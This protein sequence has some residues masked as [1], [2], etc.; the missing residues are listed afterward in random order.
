MNFEFVRLEIP[1]VILIKPKVFED[2][3]GFF[4]E[5]YKASV[6]T[7]TGITVAFVQNYHSKSK[8]K[9]LIGLHYQLEPKEQGKLVRCIKGRIWDVA[10]DI[11][12]GSPIFR[13]W[14]A[15]E[16]SKENKYMLWIPPGFAHGFLASVGGVVHRRTS[17]YFVLVRQ[18]TCSP[19]L[20]LDEG[21]Q[22]QPTYNGLS[23]QAT[24][25]LEGLKAQVKWSC[26]ALLSFPCFNY[27]PYIYKNLGNNITNFS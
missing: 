23:R 19:I 24:N 10:V 7:E 3:W 8:K 16:L 13:K 5:A 27:N 2:A 21:L 26:P 22:T 25:S 15:V 18:G 6:F 12:N 1:E 17:F 20:Q 4:M 9:V 14:V 11:R